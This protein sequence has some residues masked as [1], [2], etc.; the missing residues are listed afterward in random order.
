MLS[1]LLFLL[2]L[3]PMLVRLTSML[4]H[5]NSAQ[6]RRGCFTTLNRCI[7]L[8]ILLAMTAYFAAIHVNPGLPDQFHRLAAESFAS[9][10]T[11]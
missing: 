1:G 2:L 3:N 5:E 6:W 4:P 9:C 11:R 8:V 7:L 10:H